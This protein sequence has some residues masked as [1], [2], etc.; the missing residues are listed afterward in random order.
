MKALET[1]NPGIRLVYESFPDSPA[2]DSRPGFSVFLWKGA[3]KYLGQIEVM[4]KGR[5]A[6]ARKREVNI[7]AGSATTHPKPANK[8]PFPIVGIGASA[9]GLEAF[10]DLLR[11]LPLDTGMGFVLIQHLDPD[12]A[13]DLTHI[14]S[15][16]T[17]MPVRE[18]TDNTPVE[19]NHVY[20]IPPSASMS[21]TQGVLRLHPRPASGVFRA[22]DS[23][24]ESLAEDQRECAIGIVLSGTASD[25]TLGLEA[26][27]G[28]DGITFA[29]DKSAKYD[30]MPRSA[31][32][33]GCVDLVLPP[34]EIAKELTRIAKHPYVKEALLEAKSLAAAQKR[35]Q[36]HARLSADHA[37]GGEESS[38]E[39][40]LALLRN[41][42][43]VDFS[44]YKINTIQRRIKRRTVL[45][46]MTSLED[47]L[48][49]LIEH[50]KELDA[51]FADLLISV[52][53]FF[54]NPES[55]EALKD[56]VF[57]KLLS[58][59]RTDPV[60]VWVPGCSSGQEAYSLAMALTEF[61]AAGHAS[62]MP[63]LQMFAT[64]LNE[65]VLEKARTGLYPKALVQDLSPE[66]LRRFF[67]EEEGGFR[68]TK[69]LRDAIVFARQNLLSDPPF[70]RMDLISC[71]N[72][73]IYLEPNLQQR[74]IPSFHYALKPEGFLF[75]GASESIGA[76]TSLF[77][78][79]NRKHKI[80]ARNPGPSST[81][82]LGMVSRQPDT[83]ETAPSPP[84]TPTT[85]AEVQPAPVN[86]QREADR[87][88]LNRY[89]PPGVLLN[90]EWQVLQFRGD[91]S[92][93]LKPPTGRA[94][95]G[96]LNMAREGLRLPLR[97]AL[98][99]AKRDGRVC[100]REQLPID[101]NGQSRIISLEIV[102]LKNLREHCFLVFFEEPLARPRPQNPAMIPGGETPTRQR[103]EVGGKAHVSRIAELEREL[104]ETRDYL[105]SV[106]E[107]HEAANEELQA[108]NE[109][110]TS[111]NEELQSINE[112]LETSKEELE[113]TNEELLTVNEE[114]THSNAELGRLNSDLINF[115]SAANMTI[116]LLARDQT[117]RRFTLKGQ[118]TFN[119]TPIDVGRSITSIHHN[120]DITNLEQLVAEVMDS[121]QE[122][123]REVRDQ[124]GRWYSLRVSPYRTVN[125]IIDGAVLVLIDID[126]LKRHAQE[127]MVAREYTE[128]IIRTTRD[129]LVVLS[130]DLRIHSA[131]EVFYEMFHLSPSTVEGRLIYE[132]G[133][134]EW[135]IPQ[136]REL[137]EDI[138]PRN[139]FFTGFE[140][141]HNFASV[142][143]RVMLLN[144]R[145]LKGPEGKTQRIL[146]GI[147]DNTEIAAAQA[148]LGQ[149]EIRYRRL[150]E[151]AQ[152]GVLL[153]DPATH[154]VLDAN[155]F[156]TEL[157]ESTREELQ[158]KTPCELGLFQTQAACTVFFDR[159]RREGTLRQ[160][161]VPLRT[162]SGGLRQVELICNVYHE[163]EKEIMQWNVRDL[164]AR[165]EAQEALR[166]SEERY[167]ALAEHVPQLIWT[168]TPE[169]QFDYLNQQWANYTG[170]AAASHLGR[171]WL[172]AVH[173]DDRDRTSDCWKAALDRQQDLQLDYRLKNAAGDYRWFEV[174]GV[175]L[176]DAEGRLMKWF[177][178]C[179]DI[180]DRKRAR[181]ALERAVTER[182]AALRETVHELEAFS[183]SL[184]HDLR[185]PLRTMKGYAEL[186]AEGHGSQLDARGRDFLERISSAASRM[187][188]LV[189][190]VLSY[191]QV[192]RV[193]TPLAP[194]NLDK[195]VREIIQTY[196]EFQPPQVELEIEGTL[197]VVE[198]H[199]GFLT[200]SLSN[201]LNN[202]IKFVPP[203]AVPRVK[204]WAEDRAHEARGFVRLWIADN[205]IGIATE[206]Q[207]RI[208][209]MFERVHAAAEYE[210]TGIGLTIVRKAVERMGGRVG[211]ES[212]PGEGSK[213]WIE[214][215]K[216]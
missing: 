175:P 26:I 150:F 180:E 190:D 6:K 146:L 27:K 39:Q 106:Q 22:I 46:R 185:A 44:Q 198:A 41:H 115:Q 203:E 13:S 145:T 117:I 98:Q 188:T 89:V 152:D 69:S 63:K 42:A 11:A 1:I 61:A 20:I 174:R 68:I 159:L 56:T 134:G 101:Q 104:S 204:I 118:T 206:D 21:I 73:M 93:Y 97:A 172:E 163:D 55:F 14:L 149:S 195:L 72:L 183:Y 94:S 130:A 52:T 77:E 90:A 92:P 196:P 129:P 177:G 169:G 144:A 179:T 123:E 197:P 161:G 132:L 57:P 148:Q 15:R 214:L 192:L 64:D 189:Q 207:T 120:L 75:L 216:V 131:N 139:T 124:Q 155:P 156:L 126:A 114:M 151:A 32:G 168:S 103:E 215:R 127:L 193:N 80:Y 113:S 38:L 2:T 164:T 54:R 82:Y 45:N 199:P 8:Q 87:V 153:I 78:P 79:V 116:I 112:E 157:L 105:Q 160:V 29:Q 18:V 7:A 70:S 50:P 109:E 121:L 86:A 40:I 212:A 173:P 24:F 12:R 201:L 135:N 65:L 76:F 30:S 9:G 181:E 200:Q 102:P 209:R 202:A 143:H 31:M 96:V 33:A 108:S 187:D 3:G 110:V 158:N 162:K 28:Q 178:T 128:A 125:R 138:L 170:V 43:R 205:G 141:N 211:L 88:A 84:R 10:T 16:T 194:V 53:S 60:R 165:Q 67:V 48:R 136:L 4:K 74:I 210:G 133:N 5:P 171:G 91:T 166:Q 191:T 95:F 47:Y 111:A 62:V 140:V 99:K 34:A 176:L 100:R 122:R 184:G 167:R 71:R 19:P 142:G 37:P 51:L 35:P 119:L 81:P 137:L 186:L 17:E 154:R 25:G 107:Q 85:P 58:G 208:F 147:Q 182:T 66:R 83:R 36:T 49:F 59:R 23:F 213:F